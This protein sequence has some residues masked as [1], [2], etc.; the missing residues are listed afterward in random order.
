MSELAKMAIVNWPSM[1][2][3]IA[4][5]QTLKIRYMRSELG[6]GVKRI[7]KAFINQQLQGPPGITAGKLAK[8]KNV[9]TYAGGGNS[10]RS[11]FAKIGISR[12]LHVHEKGLTIHAKP[13]GMLVLRDKKRGKGRGDI[14]AIVPQVVI[15]PRLKFVKQ[16][17]Q[18]APKEL[19]KVAAAGARGVEVGI[20]RA[21]KRTIARI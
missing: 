13:G 15:P 5:A 12:V 4:D 17:H 19:R 3:G 16:V 9:W 8:G 6:R 1:V 2:K 7:R 10:D 11:L 20:S 14:I 21:L 18:E